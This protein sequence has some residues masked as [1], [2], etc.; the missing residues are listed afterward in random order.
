MRI[1][2]LGALGV[3]YGDV[4]TSPLYAVRETFH[5]GHVAATEANV[6]GVLS[7]V[8][9]SLVLVITVKYLRYVMRADNGG[10]GGILALFSLVDRGVLGS[11]TALG[12]LALGLFGTALLYGDGMITPAISVLSAVEGFEVATSAFEPFVLPIAV[13]ILI[14]LF[15]V[16]RRGTGSVGRVFGPIMAVWFTT[17]A[18]LG[19]ANLVGTPSVLRAVDPTLAVRFFLHN[20]RAGF[21]AL[22]SIFLAVTGAEALYADMG[23][24][25]RK[26]ISVGWFGLV[27]PALAL[28]YLGQAA[29]VIENPE[30]IENPFY[31][32]APDVLV[33]P[34][35]LL[36]TFA[37]IIASQALI[38]GAFSLT[39]QAINL[40]FCPR[41]RIVHTS[42]R[43]IG[44]VY[45]PAV[46]WVLLAACVALVLGFRSSSNLAA[47]YG[48]AVTMTMAITTILLYLVARQR[49]GW[50]LAKA[51][52]ICLP[53]L[54]VDLG[55]LG[56]NLF[57]IPAGGWF[58]LAVG[59]LVY[60]LL[61]TWKTGR[62]LVREQLRGSATQLSTLVEG[63][64]QKA[65]ARVPGTAVYLSLTPGTVPPAL[66][67]NLRNNHI[68]HERVVVLTVVTEPTAYVP[69]ARRDEI[70]DLG[71]G[72]FRMTMRFG[73]AQ[74]PDVPGA[75]EAVV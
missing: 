26:P 8:L 48:V 59:A 1:A 36:A 66:L 63:F 51:V 49:W 46:N 13:A 54:V 62:S 69:D 9:W 65:P 31:A 41:I 40:G 47:A 23:H 12:V 18:V 60:T 72:V 44:Q 15:A 30:A 28:N 43:E 56:A 6:L 61:V 45:V 10:E 4:G 37:T 68:L 67:T 50:S 21:L 75:L 33:A 17:L 14:G 32:L 25:G 11:R 3:V 7:L 39:T 73:F 53:L 64:A 35:A 22:G 57:K 38:S 34:L 16:Q 29:L 58:P 5:G 71:H 42:E 19:V 2:A 74:E 55:F 27:A 52:A 70:V 20:G 24:F